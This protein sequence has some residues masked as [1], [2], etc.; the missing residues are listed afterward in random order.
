MPLWGPLV[1]RARALGKPS[2][3][4]ARTCLRRKLPLGPDV[5]ALRCIRQTESRLLERVAA[6]LGPGTW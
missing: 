4:G 3:P 1:A 2:V 6:H 5:H